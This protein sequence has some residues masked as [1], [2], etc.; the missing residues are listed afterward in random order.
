MLDV[1]IP[2]CEGRMILISIACLRP[3][4]ALQCLREGKPIANRGR[5]QCA[6]I[7]SA[8]QDTSCF[9]IA[10]SMHKSR[11]HAYE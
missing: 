2:Y 3:A 11:D 5:T 8:S 6:D 9:F 1:E 7:F 4:D 10:K